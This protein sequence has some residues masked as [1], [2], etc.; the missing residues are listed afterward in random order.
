[1]A[2]ATA[3]GWAHLYL[4]YCVFLGV[5]QVMWNFLLLGLI[6]RLHNTPKMTYMTRI[7]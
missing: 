7:C 4:P 2:A 3:E 6:K 5:L 1:M